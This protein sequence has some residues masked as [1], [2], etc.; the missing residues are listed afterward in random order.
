MRTSYK[1]MLLA[2]F[3]VLI[4]ALTPTGSARAQGLPDRL[5]VVMI[6][7]ESISRDSASLDLA[8]SVIGLLLHLKE[9][10]AFTFVFTDDLEN[11]IGPM[12]TDADG[13]RDLRASV[14]TDMASA[15]PSGALDLVGSLAEIYN[16]L[17]GLHVDSKTTIYLITGSESPADSAAQMEKLPPVLRLFVEEGWAFFN[18]TTPATDA[19]LKAALDEI[20]AETG[21]E[22]F[23]L[24]MSDGLESMSERVLLLDARGTLIE[25]GQT[26]LAS[27]S[28]FE[29]EVG[30]V[31]GTDT[32]HILFFREAPITSFRLKN[33]DGIESSAGDRASSSV[34]DLPHVVIWE[35]VDP[36]PGTWRMEVRGTG[37]RM[38]AHM[39]ASNRYRVELQPTGA[40]PVGQP[41]GMVV[42]VL[43]GDRR[44]PVDGVTMTARVISP[45]GRSVLYELADGGTGGDAVAR[46]GFFSTTLPPVTEAGVYDVELSLMWQGIDHA[47]TSH[48]SFRAKQFPSVDVT[49]EDLDILEPGARVKVASLL[50]N[51]DG[52][53]F[54]VPVD[55]LSVSLAGQGDLGNVEIVPTR[56][57]SAGEAFAFD[58]FYTPQSQSLATLVINLNLVYAD[59]PFSYS[60]ESLVVSSIQPAPTPI[61]PTPAPTPAPAP[62]TVPHPT[63]EPVEYQSPAP[64]IAL[65]VIGALAAIILA[66]LL[67]WLTRPTPFGYFYTE[68][69]QLVIDFRALRRTPSDNL[70]SR[71]LVSGEEL[72]LP[73]F[74]GVAFEFRSGEVS[75]VSTQ[76]SSHDVRVNNQPVTD[77]MLI[78]DNS[79]IGAL[80]R[81]YVFS[82]Q[83]QDRDEDQ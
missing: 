27:G 62:T 51:I 20:S 34:I 14:E 46:D 29:V 47:V 58:V 18:V 66:A 73:G 61:P 25:I 60:T 83:P 37:G 13:F 33:P 36:V 49:A 75:I 31:P 28:V 64:M 53:P 8:R 9:G 65:I 78:Q 41:F 67:Y 57:V 81:L 56:L 16:Y 24:A 44:A 21:G 11:T 55:D 50:V 3:A 19:G 1:L 10:Q 54:S 17:K 23:D 38:S 5:T 26:T 79:W 43:E 52:Q 2:A 69:G 6:D 68:D 80:G 30:V 42:A 71:S 22:S 63:P 76:V 4:A 72:A 15:P 74:E 48:S 77:S 70:F 59:S 7:R 35:I 40:T 32:L 39:Y 45:S 82:S 12:E